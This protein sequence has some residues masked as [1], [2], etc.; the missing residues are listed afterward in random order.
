MHSKPAAYITHNSIWASDKTLD[1]LSDFMQLPL[2]PLKSLYN[3]FFSHAVA[4][5]KSCK[6][7]LM[8][9]IGGVVL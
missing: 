6:Q 9:K 8:C 2:D 3:F 1:N 5:P 7:T 4:F